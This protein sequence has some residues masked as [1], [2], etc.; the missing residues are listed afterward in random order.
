MTPGDKDS[1][2]AWERV[3]SD[4]KA[5][6]LDGAAVKLGLMDGLP[7][8]CR[9]LCVR[10]PQRGGSPVLGAQGS[11]RADACPAALPGGVQGLT[12]RGGVRR[13][14]EAAEHAWPALEASWGATCPEALVNLP[15][16]KEAL[17]VHYDFPKEHWTTLRTTNP[18]ERV[19]RECKP[20]SKAMDTIGPD[21][22]KALLALTA[23]RLEASWGAASLNNPKLK[24][25][26][27]VNRTSSTVD[28]VQGLLYRFPPRRNPS[29][30]KFLT[31]PLQVLLH[32]A[33]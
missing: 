20:R 3:F 32:K 13:G 30:T 5:R 23:L 11:Q 2:P 12:G 6:G 22:L 7:W 18:I 17:L 10:V 31:P 33:G 8:P 16:D 9:S 28:A 19:N 21:G 1:R 15:K 14:G 27:E 29:D 4:L 25:L 26:K 24:N